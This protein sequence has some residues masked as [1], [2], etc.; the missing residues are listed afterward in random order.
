M[1]QLFRKFGLDDKEIQT[2]LKLLELGAQ[3]VSVIARHVGVPR[4]SMYLILDRLKETQ[5]IEEFERAGIKYV[6]AI[7]VKSIADVLHAK[8]AQ[9]HQMEELLEDKLPE[10]EALENK[11]SIT[12]HVK[13]FEGK[14]AVMK[15][16][17]AVL[18]EKEFVAFFNPK[19]VKSTLPQYLD[20]IPQAIKEEKAKVRE[21][22]VECKEAHEYQD[23]YQSKNHQIKI[24]PKGMRF[25]SDTIITPD[26][27]FMISYGEDNVS[28]V[29]IFNKSL[30]ETQR[31][32]FDQLW[33]IS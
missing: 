25:D 27:I 10:L 15:M 18:G 21:L 6:K 4:S 1:K 28:A 8:E 26:R 2:F 22:L 3:P 13:F 16:Y 11:L 33:K 17:E 19:L 29:E 30:A 31:A 7:P 14:D 12:P 5:L 9:I 32:L 20:K 24:L 23:Q